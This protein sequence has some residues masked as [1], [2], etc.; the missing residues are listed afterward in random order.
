MGVAVCFIAL[1]TS[2]G[3]PHNDPKS[4]I[5]FGNQAISEYLLDFFC[6]EF[7]SLVTGNLKMIFQ[8]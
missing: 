4:I 2:Q 5:L 7:G 6:K 8:K 1:A 3:Q